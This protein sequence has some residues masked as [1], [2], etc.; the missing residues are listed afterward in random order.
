M[1][2]NSLSR[3]ATSIE[4]HNTDITQTHN[5]ESASTRGIGK[6]T[7]QCE[8]V[9]VRIFCPGDWLKITEEKKYKRTTDWIIFIDTNHDEHAITSLF[10]YYLLKI[11][12]V[13]LARHSRM[14]C[15]YICVYQFT[16]LPSVGPLTRRNTKTEMRLER[17]QNNR[18]IISNWTRCVYQKTHG[19]RSQRRL[20][21]IRSRPT[22]ARNITGEN[23]RERFICSAFPKFHSLERQQRRRTL[24]VCLNEKTR[25][26]ANERHVVFGRCVIFTRSLAMWRKSSMKKA[27]RRHFPT[28]IAHVIKLLSVHKYIRMLH[29]HLYPRSSPSI[30]LP[31][32]FQSF[33]LS[34]KKTHRCVHIVGELEHLL[35]LGVTLRNERPIAYSNWQ[36]H[37]YLLFRF[38]QSRMFCPVLTP[39]RKCNNT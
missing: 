3:A 33:E 21:G 18:K 14:Y 11:C 10:R 38:Q 15:L 31:I 39:R 20:C 6:I 17:A 30:V 2:N 12:V 29:C 24:C 16:F 23:H 22:N 35:L 7:W 27:E 28:P 4:N 37:L 5:T 8:W 1:S 25:N 36:P 32:I 26:A 19:S 13:E 34:G 9:L